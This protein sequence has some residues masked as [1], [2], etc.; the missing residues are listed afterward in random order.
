VVFKVSKDL[1]SQGIG[2]LSI[3]TGVPDIFMSQVIGNILYTASG[4][5]EM[6]GHSGFEREKKTISPHASSANFLAC[7]GACHTL[8]LFASPP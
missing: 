5:K 2:N 4:F 3:H 1:F 7:F 8:A 6:Y